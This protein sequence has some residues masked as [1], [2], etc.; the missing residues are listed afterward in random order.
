M[1][2]ICQAE[3]CGVDLD[4]VIDP[5]HYEHVDDDNEDAVSTV[6]GYLKLHDENPE[7]YDSDSLITDIRFAIQRARAYLPE[8]AA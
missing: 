7:K 2:R 3:D 8:G 6:A 4:D 1:A 5:K